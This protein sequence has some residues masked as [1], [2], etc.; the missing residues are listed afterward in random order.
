MHNIAFAFGAA[1]GSLGTYIF[2]TACHERKEILNKQEVLLELVQRLAVEM[3][4]TFQMNDLVCRM[5]KIHVITLKFPASTLRT[6][7]LD[8]LNR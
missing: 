2:I 4:E 8:I 5:K 1:L 7:V 6:I 3:R